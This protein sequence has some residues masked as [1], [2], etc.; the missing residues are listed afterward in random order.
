MNRKLYRKVT[1]ISGYVEYVNR[2]VVSAFLD[3]QFES[4]GARGEWN[5]LQHDLLRMQ[6][7]ELLRVSKESEDMKTE[8]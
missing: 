8:I 2:S 5:T 1:S 4:S 6:E 7:Q 3:T